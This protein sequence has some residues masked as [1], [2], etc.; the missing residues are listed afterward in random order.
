[1]G[2]NPV[3]TTKDIGLLMKVALY[4]IRGILSGKKY[5]GITN[6]LAQIIHHS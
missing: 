5:I 4:I 1:M 6:Y 3:G 2:S